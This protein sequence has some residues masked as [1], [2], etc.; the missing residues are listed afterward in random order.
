MV[1]LKKTGTTTTP[2]Y[3]HPDLLGSPRKATAQNKAVLWS[4]HYDPYGLKLNGVSQK[5]GYTGHAHDAESGYTYLQARFYDPLVGRFLSTDPIYFLDENPFSFTR[6]SYANNNPYKYK[7]PDG[8]EVMAIYSNESQSLF[9]VDR[10]TRQS[11]FV[12]AESGGRPFGDPVPAGSYEIL[13][14]AKRQGFYRLERIDSRFGDDATPEGRSNLRLH[15][16]G[17]TIGCIS[18]CQPEGFRK[19]EDLLQN[20]KRGTAEVD[21]KSIF[22][23]LTGGKETLQ[24]FGSL[25]VLSSGSSL[26]FNPETG[27]VSIRTL[28]TGSRIPREQK[29]CKVDT[30]G[31]CR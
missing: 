1:E 3:L 6:Y 25:Q 8:L 18:V 10:D 14:R 26:S 4:E 23:R 22:S 21:S 19:I 31:A 30:S 12:E 24:K 29:I 5:I 28:Q 2:T 11:A 17:R 7:D 15:G 13:E 9:M 20:T 16:P 27:Q